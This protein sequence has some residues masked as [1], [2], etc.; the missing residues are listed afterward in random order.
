MCPN[1]SCVWVGDKNPWASVFTGE[2]RP[3]SQ[4]LLKI[5]SSYIALSPPLYIYFCVYVKARGSAY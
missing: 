2:I 5:V 3:S 1:L 4:L